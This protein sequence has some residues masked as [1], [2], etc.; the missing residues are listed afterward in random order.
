VQK[1]LE[2]ND[3]SLIAQGLSNRVM[4]VYAKELMS[5]ALRDWPEWVHY[6]RIKEGLKRAMWDL[7]KKD[8]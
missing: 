3:L 4:S 5:Y 6:R 1:I 2:M 8:L 7:V